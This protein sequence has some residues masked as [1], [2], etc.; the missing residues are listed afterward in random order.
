MPSWY[1]K[2]RNPFT[3]W[4]LYQNQRCRNWWRCVVLI[5]LFPFQPK[6]HSTYSFFLY[7]S[8]DWYSYSR[9]SSITPRANHLARGG[10][11]TR[12]VALRI[13]IWLPNSAPSG[14]LTAWNDVW[15][16]INH[17]LEMGWWLESL[18]WSWHWG[19]LRPTLPVGLNQALSWHF[20]DCIADVLSAETDTKSPHQDYWRV[21]PSSLVFIVRSR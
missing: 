4:L 18:R 12:N 19:L 13:L 1:L 7:P 8:R 14:R 9:K 5:A 20:L 15:M 21:S 16:E 2:F 10:L 17:E 6:S 11:I 3:L